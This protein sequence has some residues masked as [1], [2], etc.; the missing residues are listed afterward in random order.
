MQRYYSK[1]FWHFTGSPDVNWDDVTMPREIRGWTK[2]VRD[3]VSILEM[4]LSSSKLKAG[5]PEKI[6]GRITTE[7]FCSVSDIPFKDLTYHS[8]Y[9]GKVAVGFSAEK[10]YKH[11]NPVLYIEPDFPIPID[12]ET[13]NKR[14]VDLNKKEDDLQA[15]ELFHNILDFEESEEYNEFLDKYL[16]YL[17]KFIKITRFSEKEDETFYRE[18]E[19]RSKNGDFHFEQEDIEAVIV[20]KSYVQEVDRM[21]KNLEY[22]HYVPIIPFEFLEKS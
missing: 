7:G 18:R 5:A 13:D 19:W 15:Y 17:K 12:T 22:R 6:Y 14:K 3:S 4:I 1:V 2:S 9:Y 8:E 21:L 20:P 11:F 16:G 10:I